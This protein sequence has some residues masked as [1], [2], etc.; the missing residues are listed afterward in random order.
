VYNYKASALVEQATR[1]PKLEGWNPLPLDWGDDSGKTH[2]F[3]KK[4][5]L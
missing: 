4:T 1:D 2:N 3:A 5:Q